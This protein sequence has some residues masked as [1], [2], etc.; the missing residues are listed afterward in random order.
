MFVSSNESTN[1]IVVLTFF[2]AL[3]EYFVHLFLTSL[4]FT[5]NLSF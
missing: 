3:L 5:K 4:T 1:L 2:R